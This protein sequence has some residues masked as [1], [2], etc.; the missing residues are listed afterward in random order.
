M[1]NLL[2]ARNKAYSGPWSHAQRQ[3]EGQ[4]KEEANCLH[5]PEFAALFDLWV[6]QVSTERRYTCLTPT[7]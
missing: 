6:I 2:G 5:Q 4:S 7:K 3:P 1:Y